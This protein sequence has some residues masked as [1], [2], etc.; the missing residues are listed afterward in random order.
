MPFLKK[1]GKL[2]K[3]TE[4]SI[5]SGITDK[6]MT[7]FADVLSNGALASLKHLYVDDGPLGTEHP[8]LKAACEAR[9]VHLY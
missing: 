7:E 6:G 4:F 9:R 3:L 8:A 1:G 5:G 2:C